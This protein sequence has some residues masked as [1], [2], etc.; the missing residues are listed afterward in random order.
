MEKIID[1]SVFNNK[2]YFSIVNEKDKS[3]KKKSLQE[4]ENNHKNLLEE[5]IKEIKEKFE[6]LKKFLNKLGEKMNE[7]DETKLFML[8]DSL[9]NYSISMFDF[10]VNLIRILSPYM[11]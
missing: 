6:K 11:M 5:H 8:C 4:M 9:K 2:S 10:K 1:I 3:L 7:I